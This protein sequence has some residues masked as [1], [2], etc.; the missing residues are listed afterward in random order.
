[1]SAK[2][3]F[4]T[5]VAPYVF[6][7]SILVLKLSNCLSN[8]LAK[9]FVRG[10]FYSPVDLIFSIPVV[11]LRSGSGPKRSKILL[12]QKQPRINMK[13]NVLYS[14]FFIG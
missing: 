7:N 13:L 2:I 14:M 3:P 4:Y 9:C 5:F 10:I 12:Y 8:C 6:R 1:M 11:M